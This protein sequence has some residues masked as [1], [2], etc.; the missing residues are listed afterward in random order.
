MR[1]GMPLLLVLMMVASGCKKEGCTDPLSGNFDPDA[2]VDDGSCT[3]APASLSLAVTHKVGNQPFAFNT[4]FQDANG[5][6]Y[7]FRT[8]RFHLSS[9]ELQSHSGSS[10]IDKYLQ[11]TGAATSY[12]LGE[13]PVGE[14]HGFSFDVGVDS[15]MNHGDPTLLPIAHPLSILNNNQ[16]HWSWNSGYVFLKI[17]G[18]VD[19]TSTMTGPIDKFFFY[20]IALDQLLTPVNLAQNFTISSGDQQVLSLNIDWEKALAGVDLTRQ[21]T[22]TSDNLPLAEQIMANFVTGISIE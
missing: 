13:V 7:Q 17:E 15:V 21:S 14:Y 8:A 11:I 16:D 1:F 12:D 5:R 3:Y 18:F 4:T 20:H 22:Q 9:P 19:T 6:N 2:K 10:P